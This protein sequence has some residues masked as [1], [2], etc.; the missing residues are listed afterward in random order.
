MGDSHDDRWECMVT[1]VGRGHKDRRCYFMKEES[2]WGTVFGGCSC[3]IPYTDGVPCHHM[4]A[5]VKSSRIEGLNPNNAMPFWW[6]TECWRRQYP[7]D[8]NVTCNFGSVH[9]ES[10]V[11]VVLVDEMALGPPIHWII[12]IVVG[13]IGL[14]PLINL[15]DEPPLKCAVS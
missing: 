7:A 11:L 9:D 4:I 8:A 12:F 2:E 5:M 10:S 13:V 1:R 3:G 14:G 6:T 15:L